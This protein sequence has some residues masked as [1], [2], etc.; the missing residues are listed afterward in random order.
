MSSLFALNGRP[1]PEKARPALAR[2][3]LERQG[4]D[5]HPTA[6]DLA[7]VPTGRQ[8][9]VSGRISRQIDFEGIYVSLFQA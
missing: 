4:I 3:A 5:S 8:I 9:A 6:A 1:T 2:E 7:Y